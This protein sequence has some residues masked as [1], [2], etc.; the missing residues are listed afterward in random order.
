ME[1]PPDG[2]RVG[3][4]DGVGDVL[5]VDK[6]SLLSQSEGKTLLETST[7]GAGA[8]CGGISALGG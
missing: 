8:K 7:A 4:S 6:D 1:T 3:V 5:G 2:E